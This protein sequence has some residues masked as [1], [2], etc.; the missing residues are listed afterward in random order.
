MKTTNDRERLMF[1]ATPIGQLFP[2]FAQGKYSEVEF[3]EFGTEHDWVEEV[4]APPS[5]GLWVWEYKPSGGNYDSWNGDFDGVQ[6][7]NGK[8]RALTSLEWHFIQ[9]GEN[10][11]V[12]LI[13]SEVHEARKEESEIGNINNLELDLERLIK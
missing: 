1:V 3:Y 10:P 8:W 5:I 7:D 6:I 13:E 12:P 11:W 9:N 2:M 4:P